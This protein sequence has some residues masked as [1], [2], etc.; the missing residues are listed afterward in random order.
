MKHFTLN[1]FESPDEAG[2][3][4]KM[5][6]EFLLMLNEAREEAGIPFIITSGYRTKQHNEDVG[7]VADSSH[8]K[9]LACD[10]ASMDS[11]TRFLIVGA[12][13]EVGFNR[14]GIAGTFIHID[15]DRDKTQFLIWRY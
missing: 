15:L 1:E 10:I 8:L 9:G 4:K 3:G 2:S 13:L 12:L 7:G 6:E 14:I 11:R 5:D